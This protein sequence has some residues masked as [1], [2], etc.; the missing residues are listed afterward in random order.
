MHEHGK[1]TVE[2]NDI[3]QNTEAGVL[4]S[5]FGSPEVRS[6]NIH[7]GKE[8]GVYVFDEGAGTIV[9]NDIGNNAAA[10]IEVRS[11][12]N[13]TASKNQ[14]HDSKAGVYANDSGLGVFRTFRKAPLARQRE[15]LRCRRGAS[16]KSCTGRRI[17]RSRP[18]ARHKSH[19]E[20]PRSQWR[21]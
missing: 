8:S 18:R 12:G 3:F 1:G 7:D 16:N 13:P 19:K 21:P 2:N 15:S 17:S 9:E 5:T 14:I 20:P 4:I 11:A 10:G 6:N